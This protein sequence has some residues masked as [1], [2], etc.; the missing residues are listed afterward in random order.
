MINMDTMVNIMSN[1]LKKLMIDNQVKNEIEKKE[2]DVTR[3]R[4]I[5]LKNVT[6]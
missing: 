2:I 4:K 6:H 3:R 1:T 5:C